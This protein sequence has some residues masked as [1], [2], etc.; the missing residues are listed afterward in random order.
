MASHREGESIALLGRRPRDRIEGEAQHHGDARGDEEGGATWTREGTS[1]GER[2]WESDD[3][4]AYASARDE[5]LSAVSSERGAR[6]ARG[7]RGAIAR[8]T[9]AAASR[10]GVVVAGGVDVSNAGFGAVD[11]ASWTTVYEGFVD[12]RGRTAVATTE[13]DASPAS[14]SGTR[15]HPF[16]CSSSTHRTSRRS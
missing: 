16:G 8:A 12:G 7:R 4:D 10:R 9:L 6:G 1:D 13:A 14:P 5:G 11:D 3:E 2:R 15:T